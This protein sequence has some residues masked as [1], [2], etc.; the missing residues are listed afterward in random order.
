MVRFATT[1][2]SRRPSGTASRTQRPFGPAVVV[3]ATLVLGAGCRSYTERTAG[4]MRAFEAGQLDRASAAFADPDIVPSPFLSGVEAGMVAFTAGDWDASL[5]HFERAAATVKELEQESVISPESA[6]EL[7]L[8]FAF[9]DTVHDYLGEGYERVLMHAC[10]GLVYLA[11]GQLEDVLVEVRLADRLLRNEEKLYEKEY[12]A[13]GL[14]HL[15]SGLAYELEG[16]LDEAYIDYRRLEEKGLARELVGPTLVRLADRLGF[17]DAQLWRERYGD[18]PALPEGA[19][20]IVV[21]AGVGVGPYKRD[22]T[23][24]LPGKHALIQWSV[25]DFVRRPQPVQALELESVGEGP[26]IRTVVVEEVHRVAAA[27]LSDRIA[28]LAAKSAAR[29]ALKY[30]A[31]RKLGDETGAVGWLAGTIFTVASERADLRSWT[32]LPDTWQACRLFVAPGEHRVR[33]TAVGGESHDLGRFRLQPGETM[34]VLARTV[35]PLLFAHVVGGQALEAPSAPYPG[36]VP[37]DDGDSD[38]LPSTRTSP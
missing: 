30:E 6:A 35:G 11:R 20:R 33:L 16:R 36:P 32:T 22:I 4:A 26:A 5:G 37:F 14:G 27:N 2:M 23:I 12:A 18:P 38:T 8:S 19:A 25:P 24:T 7:V 28:W 1:S 17:S 21:L 9:N 15:L 3:T 34:F 10:T 13:G 31:T 29:A